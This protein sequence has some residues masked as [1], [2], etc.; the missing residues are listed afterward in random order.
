MRR[1]LLAA[2]LVATT[3]ATAAEIRVLAASSLS[4]AL[5]E[6]AATYEPT[7]G[8]AIVYSFGAS[9]LL[10][11]QIAAGAPADLF[12]SADEASVALLAKQ[13]LVGEVQG[14]L[15]NTLVIAV[16]ADARP[17]APRDLA[18]RAVRTIAMG[19]PRTVP[20]GIYARAWLMRER[21][22]AA[23]SKKVIPTA[24]ARA[25]LAAVASGDVDAAI[26]YRTDALS[27]KGVRIA[28]EVP[29]ESA[30]R[31]RYPF[32][33]V[34]GGDAAA[35]RFLRHLRSPAALDVFA[36]HGFLVPSRERRTAR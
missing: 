16:P 20:A 32:A 5:Q 9:N 29:R 34:Q 7:S 27:S 36:K 1:I 30:P 13:G 35:V 15:S 14:V 19:E 12:V 18:S 31:I 10:A 25:A 4:D 6:I 11:R 23:V 8:D 26:V 3:T 28:Y 22:W 33:I 24:T 17:L 2:V 21:L